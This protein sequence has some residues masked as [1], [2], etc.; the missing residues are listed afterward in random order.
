MQ[1]DEKGLTRPPIDDTYRPVWMRTRREFSVSHPMSAAGV[2][3]GKV[4][5][6]KERYHEIVVT[7]AVE[8]A[9]PF[10]IR[11]ARTMRGKPN[12]SSTVAELSS[13][14]VEAEAA[15]QAIPS[16]AEETAQPANDPPYTDKDVAAYETSG[17]CTLKPGP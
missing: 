6:A 11:C 4:D 3:I 9:I 2:P 1:A 13:V 15:A 10:L 12:R 7:Q 8:P 17:T 16:M 14:E 5:A